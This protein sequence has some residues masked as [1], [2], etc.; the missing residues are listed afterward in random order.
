MAAS[1]SST[2]TPTQTRPLFPAEPVEYMSLETGDGHLFLVDKEA[3][4]RSSGT[5][6]V[7]IEAQ[8]SLDTVD[9]LEKGQ[10]FVKLEELGAAAVAGVLEYLYWR[11]R[12]INVVSEKIQDW[13]VPRDKPALIQEMLAAAHFLEV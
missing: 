7:M 5:L 1:S 11:K 2:P 3:V 8:A 6:R 13:P 9:D 10:K 4:Q 12:W